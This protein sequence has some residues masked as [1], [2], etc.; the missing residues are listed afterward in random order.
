MHTNT[1]PLVC[2]NKQA[3][4]N[5]YNLSKKRPGGRR[6][7]SIPEGAVAVSGGSVCRGP[8]FGE[9]LTYHVYPRDAYRSLLTP[10]SLRVGVQQMGPR[11]RFPE[12]RT[13]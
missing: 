13:E 7:K 6:Q 3:L 2:S 9:R 10:N 5:Y 12:P 8:D 4:R 1:T 11:G